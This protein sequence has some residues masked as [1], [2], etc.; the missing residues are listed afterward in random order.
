MDEANVYAIWRGMFEKNEDV[1]RVCMQ[2]KELV[3]V[4]D[5]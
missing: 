5:R 3:G 1:I 2:A 4:R